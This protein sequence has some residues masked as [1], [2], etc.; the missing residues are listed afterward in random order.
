MARAYGLRL[1]AGHRPA[2]RRADRRPDRRPGV[3]A[4]P[5]GREQGRLLHGRQAR[6]SRGHRPRPAHV[7]DP[8]RGGELHGRLAVPGRRRGQPGHRPGRDDGEPAAAGGRVLGAGQRRHSLGAA[9]R[10]G[11][12]RPG[13]QVVR[14]IKAKPGG[15]VPVSAQ[16][17][18]TSAA[19]LAVHRRRTAPPAR[20]RSPASR[21]TRSWS[22]AR[23]APPRSSASRTRPGSRP[24][25]R[26]QAGPVRRGRDDRAGRPRR[27]GRRAGRRAIYADLRADRQEGRLPGRDRRPVPSDGNRERAPSARSGRGLRGPGGRRSV[28]VGARRRGR[29]TGAG[30]VGLSDER[31]R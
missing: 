15:N 6:L 11:G 13:R 30:A 1:A 24:G 21:W 20:S 10:A 8:A 28:V 16:C 25:R 23:P 26:R 12:R 7:P 18:A 9:A 22:A 2:G 5:L 29:P 4:D 3:Q 17:S 27:P 31:A 14:E 19:S